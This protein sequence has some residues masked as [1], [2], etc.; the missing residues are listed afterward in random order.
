M[1]S[2]VKT[3]NMEFHPCTSEEV[4]KVAQS[5]KS[6]S[7]GVDGLSLRALKMILG[8]IL[9]RLVF[10]INLSLEKGGFPVQFKVV[11]VIPFHKSGRKAGVENWRPISILS[12]FSKTL[13]KVVHKRLYNFL[14]IYRLLSQ[15]QFG[16]RKGHSLTDAL[17]SLV[18]VLTV[19]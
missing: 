19:R 10:I 11:K 9:P 2:V 17:Q 12:I 13:E 5:L 16:F 1:A 15:T 18:Q 3:L 8:I 7:A 6:N 14:W 4:P